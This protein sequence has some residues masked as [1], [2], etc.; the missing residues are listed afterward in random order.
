[1]VDAFRD[2]VETVV[3]RPAELDAHLAEARAALS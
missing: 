1:M 2:V 3:R